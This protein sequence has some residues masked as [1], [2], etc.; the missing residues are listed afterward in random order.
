MRALAS[1]LSNNVAAFRPPNMTGPTLRK[2]LAL[3][4]VVVTEEQVDSDRF[5]YVRGVPWLPA[6]SAGCRSAR[7]TRAPRRSG[8]GRRSRRSAQRPELRPRLHR[9]VQCS[10]T[11]S[12]SRAR[13]CSASSASSPPA[14]PPPLHGDR[15]APRRRRRRDVDGDA[16]SA[17]RAAA[18]STCSMVILN[19]AAAP[20]VRPASPAPS[21]AR[22][23]GM[24]R[25]ASADELERSGAA[26][27]HRPCRVPRRI[28]A[29][30][31]CRASLLKL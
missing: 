2:L 4:D 17:S 18:G 12:S 7:A 10:R 1:Y 5:V 6:C 3:L 24:P 13:R 20:S 21:A 26:R 30:W 16:R 14:S 9:A 15:E 23:S 25:P 19:V 27:S 22:V 29:C 11:S 31:G 8:R 28:R